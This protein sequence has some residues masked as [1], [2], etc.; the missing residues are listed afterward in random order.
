MGRTYRET[1]ESS[2]TDYVDSACG[3]ARRPSGPS[4]ARA[5][6]ASTSTSRSSTSWA[7]AS[8]APGD[9]AQAYV[10]A[11]EVGHHVQDQLGISDAVSS[12][13]QRV[14][15]EEANR[16]SVRL[17]LQA[18]F[19]A[20]VWAHYAERLRVWPGTCRRPGRRGNR[21][22]PAERGAGHEV[23]DRSPMAHLLAATTST[24]S[25]PV[26]GF[27]AIVKDPRTWPIFWVGM[28]ESPRVF[29]DGSP[30]TKAEFFQHMMGMKLRM[31]DRTSRGAQPERQ[32]RLALGVRRGDPRRDLVS[33]RA[34]RRRH[35]RHHDVRLRRAAEAR[36]PRRGPAGPREAHAPRLRRQHGQPQAARRD[37]R[38]PGGHRDGLTRTPRPG[39]PPDVR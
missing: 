8:A 18:D 39:P 30:G 16:L 37:Q 29:G 25:L 3:S 38:G 13:Q 17:E 1:D 21:G 10:I 35:G 28:E 14:P 31:V 26:D 5:T 24:L 12:R 4:T 19:L 32:H 36:R 27:D 11:H 7:G 22:G 34:G 33:P 15:Q 23:P 2:S 20:G 9:F 6:R